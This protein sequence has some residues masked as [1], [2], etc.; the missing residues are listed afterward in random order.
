[1]FS[2]ADNKN[3]KNQLKDPKEARTVYQQSALSRPI[4]GNSQLYYPQMMDS[5]LPSYQPEAIDDRLLQQ[6][7][8]E[9]LS[10]K[11]L[12]NLISEAQ[13]ERSQTNSL[14]EPVQSKPVPELQQPADSSQNAQ[15]LQN[16]QATQ[17]MA[18]LLNLNGTQ[19]PTMIAENILNLFNAAMMQINTSLTKNIGQSNY[20]DTL[21]Q[22]NLSNIDK[23][24]SAFAK[25]DEPNISV[26]PGTQNTQST[27]EAPQQS[28][29]K[30]KTDHTKPNFFSRLRKEE[31]KS[32]VEQGFSP[33]DARRDQVHIAEEKPLKPKFES[34]KPTG[35]LE[36]LY[37][38]QRNIQEEQ[39]ILKQRK[40]F[41]TPAQTPS[42]T[43]GLPMG[44]GYYFA[45]HEPQPISNLAEYY[46]EL[47][48]ENLSSSDGQSRPTLSHRGDRRG[49]GTPSVHENEMFSEGQVFPNEG[50]VAS[51][52]VDVPN[53]NRTLGAESD[54]S[55]GEQRC[56]K[57]Y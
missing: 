12:P 27:R 41:I 46:K 21:N 4:Q 53:F 36:A 55:R 31:Q 22:K 25:R 34:K 37:Q 20:V 24:V 56:K 14:F 57:V 9:T 48:S 52:H 6:L 11:L 44:Q 32:E 3:I 26:I 33:R 28:S 49:W 39:D 54:L 2:D 15:N 47:H 18:G 29:P 13:K 43:Y 10:E 17:Q 19:L 30:S 8:L 50:S 42:N 16:M 40:H 35:L 45:N 51:E 5:Q 23:A 1:M 7:A 38:E